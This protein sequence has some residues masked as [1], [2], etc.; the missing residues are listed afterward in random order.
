MVAFRFMTTI[1]SR[2]S[3]FDDWDKL[4]Q[5]RMARHPDE[6]G[7]TRSAAE[8]ARYRGDFVKS[9]Q[10]LKDL[11]D[12]AKATQSDL[13]SFAWDALFLPGEVQQ[14]SIEAAE[15]ANQMSQNADYSIMHTLAC[16]YTHTGKAARGRELLLNAMEGKLEEPDS[17]V[18]LAYA[19]IA[20]AYGEPDAA[21]A[22]YARVEKAQLEGPDSNFV[23]AQQRLLALK[24]SPATSAK[25]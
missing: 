20:E 14:E 8:L 16:L 15:R 11:A 10:L 17:S 22:M 24:K 3:R 25:N 1:Y 9:R 18:W 4:V 13:N 19:Q 12:H 2:T 6:L 23:L 5:E 21:Q 7:Y